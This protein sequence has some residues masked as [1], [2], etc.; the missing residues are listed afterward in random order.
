MGLDTMCRYSLIREGQRSQNP[1]WKFARLAIAVGKG[2]H[3]RDLIFFPVKTA[4][5]SLGINEAI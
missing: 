4:S 3:F 2:I 5:Y 1:F